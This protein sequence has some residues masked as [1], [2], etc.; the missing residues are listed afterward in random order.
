MA[1]QK[2]VNSGFVVINLSE[3]FDANVVSGFRSE[4][5]EL[6]NDGSEKVVFNL[7]NLN[8]I[9]STGIGLIVYIYKRLKAGGGILR[10]AGPVGQPAE[11]IDILKVDKV[12]EVFPDTETACQ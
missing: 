11:L 10:I 4:L 5:E 12:I 2:E 8:F 6:I 9:D 1:V 3:D 7:K